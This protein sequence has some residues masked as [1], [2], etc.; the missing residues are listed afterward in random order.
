MVW[1]TREL[2]S[3]YGA[4]DFSFHHHVQAGSEDHS[5]SDA[6]EESGHEVSLPL[7]YI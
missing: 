1:T 6:M 5:A 2:G 3:D 4:R 7:T